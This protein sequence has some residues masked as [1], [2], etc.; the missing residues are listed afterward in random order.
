MIDNIG[1]VSS[2]DDTLEP[3]PTWAVIALQSKV[4]LGV[5]FGEQGSAVI[6][7]ARV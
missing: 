4:R 3:R 7:D 2:M 5:S 1:S 6:I